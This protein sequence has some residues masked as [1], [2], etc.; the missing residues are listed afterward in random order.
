MGRRRGEPLIFILQSNALLCDA[1]VHSNP[2]SIVN[3]AGIKSIRTTNSSSTETLAERPYNES[4]VRR[5]CDHR[6]RIICGYFFRVCN[7]FVIWCTYSSGKYKCIVSE[8]ARCTRSESLSTHLFKLAFPGWMRA[9]EESIYLQAL[10]LY[11]LH[12]LCLCIYLVFV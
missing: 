7:L 12:I 8:H 4:Q 5:R 11:L 3:K 6:V 2:F 1:L 9:I 10:L